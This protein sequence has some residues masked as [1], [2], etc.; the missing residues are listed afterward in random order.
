MGT[1]GNVVVEED[2]EV[3]VRIYKQFDSYPDGLGKDLVEILGDPDIVNGYGGDAEVPE[4]FNGMGC[5][6]AYLIKHLKKGIGNVYINP[7]N[8]ESGWAEYI[9][10]LYAFE[11]DDGGETYP[12]RL[13]VRVLDYDR[14]TL[15]DGPLPKMLPAVKAAEKIVNSAKFS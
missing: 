4:V 15:Y 12:Q 13:A 14:N 10:V 11:P 5:L 6:A 2:G 7:A 3:L 8:R 9:Y 1:R